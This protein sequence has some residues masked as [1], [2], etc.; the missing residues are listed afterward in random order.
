MIR[1]LRR[2][3]RS[4]RIGRSSLLPMPQLSVAQWVIGMHIARTTAARDRRLSD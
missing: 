3:F 2:L 1:I 4:A